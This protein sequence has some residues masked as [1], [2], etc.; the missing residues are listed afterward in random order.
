[1]SL[2]VI[3]PV[4]SVI[5]IVII[6]KVIVSIVVVSN[7]VREMFYITDP[8]PVS[9]ISL[10]GVWF[11]GVVLFGR[12]FIF[13]DAGLEIVQPVNPILDGYSIKASHEILI[14]RTSCRFFLYKILANLFCFSLKFL[15]LF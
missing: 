6:S 2:Y 11:S 5:S 1:M 8:W 15:M 13:S 10:S 4:L 12:E 3:L 7:F 14:L 9:G